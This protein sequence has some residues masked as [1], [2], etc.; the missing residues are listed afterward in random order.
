[1][2][3]LKT[4]NNES[5]LPLIKMDRFGPRVQRAE[6]APVRVSAVN[7]GRKH[8]RCSEL[9]LVVASSLGSLSGV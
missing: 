3:F 4:L 6:T 5:M 2:L 7:A 8:F 1:M 9:T